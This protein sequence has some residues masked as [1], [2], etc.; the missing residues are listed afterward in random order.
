[1][2]LGLTTWA[3]LLLMLGPGL[4]AFARAPQLDAVAG[5]YKHRVQVLTPAAGDGP[6]EDILEV[7]RLSP[8]TAYFR[9]HEEMANGHI[10]AIHGVADWAMDALVY[11][12]QGDTPCILRLVPRPGGI[13]LDDQNNACSATNCGAG[14]AMG[15]GTAVAFEASERR[16]IRYLARILAS[17]NMPRR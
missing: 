3:A 17:R 5:V 8:T 11:R 4:P 12:R 14:S 6:H 15:S 16:R 1:M 10:C 13:A 9:I 7:V 2:R